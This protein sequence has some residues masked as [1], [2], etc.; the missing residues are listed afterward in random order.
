M[1][2]YRLFFLICLTIGLLSGCDSLDWDELVES[3]SGSSSEE[4]SS[5]ST[6]TS[7]ST[8]TNIKSSGIVWKPVAE[9][10]GKLVVLT[11]SSFGKS[12]AIIY[13]K[14]KKEKVETG[15]YIG[16]TNGNRATYRFNKPGKEY[17]SPCLLYVKEK[18]YTV[19]DASKRYN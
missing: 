8:A 19:D 7:S 9:S 12:T 6:S 3:I 13:S 10:D 16:N 4:S 15:R 1:K 14:D 18:Y 17:T 2:L 11:P 5:T